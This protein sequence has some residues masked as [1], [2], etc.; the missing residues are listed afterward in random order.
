MYLRSVELF[1]WRSYRTVRFDFPRPDGVRNVILI[2]GPNEYGKTS[3][4]EAVTLGL[5]GRDG[6]VLIPR[7]RTDGDSNSKGSIKINYSSFLQKAVSHHAVESGQHQCFISLEWEDDSGD[8]VEIKRTWYFRTSGQHRPAEDQLQ[9]FQGAARRPL[10]CPS[11]VQDKDAWYR[12]WIAQRF[13]PPSLGEFFLFDGEQVQRYANRDMD[14]QVRQ[15]IEGLLGLPVLRKVKESLRQYA[16]NRRSQ[17]ALPKDE[18]VDNIKKEIEI[19][20]GLISTNKK[21]REEANAHLPIIERDI[22]DIGRQLNGRTEGTVALVASIHKDEQR[23]RHEAEQAIRDLTDLISADLALAIAGE[24]LRGETLERLRAEEKRETWEASREEGS[25]NLDRFVD[26]LSERIKYRVPPI[27]ED[28]HHAIVEQARQAWI[29]IWHPPPAG[30][31]DSYL[32][33]SLKGSARTRA[34]DRLEVV[35]RHTRTEITSLL[36]RFESARMTADQKQRERLEIE[37]A[38]PEQ[39]KILEQFKDLSEQKGRYIEQRNGAQREIDTAETRLGQARAEF[40]RYATQ[41]GKQ[42][43]ALFYAEQADAYAKLIDDLLEDAVPYEVEEVA[44]EMTKAWKKMAHMPDRLE[45]IE[46]SS[47]CKVKMLTADGNDLHE[48][49]KPS[50]ASQ[51]FTQALITAITKVSERTFPFIV[52]TPLARLSLEQRLGVLKTFTDRHGQ[53]IL[54]STDQEVVDD[55]LEAIRDRIIIGYELTVNSDR[56]V[57]VTTVRELDL[58]S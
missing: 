58:G 25:K 32:H 54:L 52:D 9:I 22:Q 47:D 1:N 43:P 46:I 4:F 45:R 57:S 24:S 35:D 16:Q 12:E 8:P 30:Y 41:H 33:A 40:G 6:L 14:Q 19:L 36:H 15:G 37:S 44:R 11:T 17:A 27:S 31:A 26:N 56:G 55:K 7:A 38:G 53:V 42:G 20:E 5:Y 51:V 2:R 23:Y 48:V 28:Q 39:D 3:L 13:L 18:K 29:G 34:V 21:N 49:E 10:T 50:G